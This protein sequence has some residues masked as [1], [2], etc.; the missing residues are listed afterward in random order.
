MSVLARSIFSRPICQ[1]VVR[2]SAS[3]LSKRLK[4]SERI[5][6][7]V[8]QY[9]SSATSPNVATHE[10][11]TV[12]ENEVLERGELRYYHAVM[13]RSPLFKP[14]IFTA[15]DL[16]SVLKEAPPDISSFLVKTDWSADTAPDVL[17][18]FRS[19]AAYSIQN[20]MSIVDPKFQS[21]CVA[22]SSHLSKFSD[23]ELL[24]LGKWI[25]NWSTTTLGSSVPH[26]R[27]LIKALNDSWVMRYGNWTK[28]RDLTNILKAADITYWI[29]NGSRNY[30]RCAI[31][32]SAMRSAKEP[33]HVLQLVF[34]LALLKPLPSSYKCYDLEKKIFS[35]RKS[36]SVAE[37]LVFLNS[38]FRSKSLLQYHPLLEHIL[39]ESLK[40]FSSL[41]DYMLV[42]VSKS[43]GGAPESLKPLISVFQRK[44]LS[45]I[46]NF[47]IETII[48]LS[49]MCCSNNIFE[50]DFAQAVYERALK[51]IGMLRWKELSRLMVMFVEHPSP[52]RDLKHL[53]ECV[54]AE[55]TGR[56]DVKE[57]IGRKV[58]IL[59]AVLHR[60]LL[61]G[62][63]PQDLLDLYL[64]SVNSEI[65]SSKALTAKEALALDVHLEVFHPEY[66]GIRLNSELRKLICEERFSS[67]SRHFQNSDG[68]IGFRSNFNSG[69]AKRMYSDILAVAGS[70]KDHVHFK[71]LVPSFGYLDY[72]LR[73]NKDGTYLPIPTEITECEPWKL[74]LIPIEHLENGDKFVAMTFFSSQKEFER[75]KIAS[76][77]KEKTEI[78]KRL[79][80]IH[81]EVATENWF[82]ATPEFRQRGLKDII[83]NKLSESNAP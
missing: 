68:S 16:L 38:I 64:S 53:G 15:Q 71:Q 1:K 39:V 26:Y 12:E 70:V 77:Q 57:W 11:E 31:F 42:T 43:C 20:G 58:Y 78:L 83:A 33:H 5:V 19:V 66:N 13:E 30:L 74:P 67:K 29:R 48:H 24:E 59:G 35:F 49:W 7:F 27:D 52:N 76:L 4:Y 46:D 55:M 62:L 21:I 60:F 44:V 65:S 22:I 72:L 17:E 28:S 69:P 8:S 51:D 34:Y 54:I 50:E 32:H 25:I 10:L 41:D 79:G 80:Y 18:A 6:K 9:S 36:Y 37:L 61:C 56:K 40:Q 2:Y 82:D 75:R 14:T 73:L 23:E 47:R 63:C 81:I 3:C 45:K